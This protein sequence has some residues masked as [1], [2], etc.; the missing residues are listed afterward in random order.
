[1]K[2]NWPTKKLGPKPTFDFLTKNVFDS[3]DLVNCEH[4]NII[5]GSFAS[6]V[7]EFLGRC[8]VDPKSQ[9]NS[10]NLKKFITEYL[11]KQNE[12][13]KKYVDILVKNFRNGA[14]HS[15]LAKPGVYLTF[16]GHKGNHIDL[17]KGEKNNPYILIYSPT[18][19]TDLKNAVNSFVTDARKD[20]KLMQ[21]YVKTLAEIEKEGEET[22]K[23]LGQ[24]IIDGL[25]V[26]KFQRTIKF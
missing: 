15:V 14:S 22:M 24:E 13:Y 9:Q 25:I 8:L 1:M 19:I 12:L 26:H 11:A 2:N 3:L 7:M 21:A 23:S 4:K 6:A 10:K 5:L 20:E 18:F 17:Y 16:A